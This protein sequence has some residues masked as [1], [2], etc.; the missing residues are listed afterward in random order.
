MQQLTRKFNFTYLQNAM[1]WQRSF[2]IAAG[3]LLLYSVF[4]K[5]RINSY[6]TYFGH[7]CI[8]KL[9]IYFVLNKVVFW[10]RLLSNAEHIQARKIIQPRNVS[11]FKHFFLLLVVYAI[12]Q[13]SS[14]PVPVGLVADTGLPWPRLEDQFLHRLCFAEEATSRSRRQWIQQ[15]GVH[16]LSQIL[17]RYRA[18]EPARE[19]VREQL[20]CDL[21]ASC[22]CELDSVME[23]GLSSAILLAG[24]SQTSSRTG[25]R[26]SAN[27]SATTFEARTCLRQVGNHVCDQLVS[28][29]HIC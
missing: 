4:L 26:R 3:W 5:L 20:F 9:T 18:S 6:A 25:H 19:L 15:T 17:L 10:V 12:R 22:Y 11:L 21:Q 14:N 1:I 27:R 29:S 28:W 13:R 7:T 23:F 8:E 16:R 24:R 2:I